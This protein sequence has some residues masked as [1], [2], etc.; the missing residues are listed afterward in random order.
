MA[1]KLEKT[2]LPGVY[3]AHR[4]G[5]ARSG[6]CGCPYTVVSRHRGKQHKTTVTTWSE[7]RE[8]KGSKDAGNSR[9]TAKTRLDAYY[10]GWIEAY[11][12]RTSKGF[13]ETSREEYRRVIEK[14]ILPRWGTW[15]M[16]DVEPTD[17]RGLFL[18][19]RKAGCSTSELKKTRAAGSA[20]FATAVE[21]GGVVQSNAFRDV[22]LPPGP[23]DE[24]PD[25]D[26]QAKALS[27][28]ELALILAAI[29]DEWRL[30]FEL[31]VHTGCRIGEAVALNWEHLDLNHDRPRVRIVEQVY[32]GKRK[33][34]KN[35]KEGKRV[36]PL[37]PGM[38]E[39]LL[40]HRAASYRG[41]EAPVFCSPGAL[42]RTPQGYPFPLSPQNFARDVLH[43]AREALGMQWVTFHTFRHTCASLLFDEGRNLKQVQ[44]WLGHAD[45]RFTLATY[46]HV[47]DDELG[48]ADFFDD[49]VK[50]AGGNTG[51]TEGP[52]ATENAG[53][54]EAAELAA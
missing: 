35:K 31:L 2:T 34:L 44:E 51:A 12:G 15:K 4:K 3:R 46:V 54:A 8:L 27:R 5:C 21:D 45:P 36:L 23:T 30:F 37:A 42:R 24:D 50:I 39:K 38:V 13:T 41:E 9:P 19:M 1:A 49:V 22:R 16:A 53:T 26:D 18:A 52:Q 17:V 7:A 47:M 32:R 6:R 40:A 29:P 33:K 25:T 43:P 10:E 20:M 48:E 28:E 14:W 11:A